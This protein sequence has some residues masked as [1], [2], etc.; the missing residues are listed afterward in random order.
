MCTDYTDLNPKDLYPLSSINQLVDGDYGYEILS[1]IDAYSGYNQIRL[2][3]P[4]VKKTTFMS[5]RANYCY[6][7]IPFSFKNVEATYQRLMYRAFEKQIGKNIEV[8]VDDIVV[9]SAKPQQHASDLQ[10]IFEQLTRYNMRLNPEKC[11][12]RIKSGKFL[13]FMLT[14]EGI[15]ANPDK[16]KAIIEMRRPTNVK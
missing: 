7:I 11:N 5:N 4:D 1:L 3:A 12:F 14:H 6:Q 13:G 15:E 10:E 9:K 8:Y 2:F 16:C